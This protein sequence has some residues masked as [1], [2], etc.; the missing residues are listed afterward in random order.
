MNNKV[1]FLEF[2][3]YWCSTVLGEHKD[4]SSYLY[5]FDLLGQTFHELSHLCHV[6]K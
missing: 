6:Q 5:C 3:P 4:L 2:Y 1:L